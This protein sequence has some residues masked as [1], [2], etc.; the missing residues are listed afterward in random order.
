[1]LHELS[2]DLHESPLIRLEKEKKS[3]IIFLKVSK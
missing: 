2:A 1:M 3:I